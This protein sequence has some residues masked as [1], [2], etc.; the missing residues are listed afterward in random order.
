MIMI[1]DELQK[2]IFKVLDPLGGKAYERVAR[3][4]FKY[5]EEGTLPELKGAEQ[6]T[7]NAVKFIIDE[8]KMLEFSDGHSVNSE[9]C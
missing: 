7:F 4:I 1:D 9:D 6:A 5:L 3:A 8:N 2:N